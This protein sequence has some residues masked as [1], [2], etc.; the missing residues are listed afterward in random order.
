MNTLL[1]SE[2]GA[3]TVDWVV[4]TAAL[5]GLG[6]A[7]MGVVSTGV[8][9]STETTNEVLTSYSIK[10][11]FETLLGESGLSDGRGDWTGGELKS[12]AGF[13]D[14]LALSGNAS[15]AELPID[16]DEDFDFAIVEFDMIVGDSWDNETGT[17]TI[18]GEDVVVSSHQVYSDEPT[19]TT[20]DGDAKTTVTLTRTSVDTGNTSAHWTRRGNEDHTYRVRVVAAND[21]GALTLGA[22]TT[23]N[24]GANDEFF[25]IDNVTVSGSDYDR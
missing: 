2:S 11:K 18:N 5:V 23:L 17:I 9:S 16:V 6:L 14:I 12:I 13:G 21:G 25:G 7:T 4:L 19:I 15:T 24:Q 8:E 1:T 10:T 20:I 22:S 3:V